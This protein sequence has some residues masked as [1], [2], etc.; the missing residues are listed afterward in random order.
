MEK[1]RM[2]TLG[3]PDLLVTVD[4]QSLIPIL[5]DRSLAEIPNPRLYR[6]KEKCM[7]YRFDIQ[8]LAGKKNDGPDCMSRAFGDEEDIDLAEIDQLIDID[9]FLDEED[10]D[11]GAAISACHISSVEEVFVNSVGK[12]PADDQAVTFEEIA[13]EGKRDP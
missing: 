12:C 6:L 3:C 4:H 5:G 2:F 9:E 7:R 1:A 8:Y 13:Q 11:L 10:A